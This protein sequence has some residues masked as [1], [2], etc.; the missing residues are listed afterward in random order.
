[1]LICALLICLD[2]VTDIMLNFAP[3]L[4]LVSFKSLIVNAIKVLYRKVI[5]FPLIL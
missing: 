1:M 3:Y 2:L 5:T 4:S